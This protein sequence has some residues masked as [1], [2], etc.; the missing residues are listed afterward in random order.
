VHWKSATSA[1]LTVKVR[2]RVRLRKLA[3]GKFRAAVSAAQSFAGKRATFQRYSPTLRRWVALRRFTLRAAGA[4]TLPLNPT[5]LSRATFRS[6]VKRRLRV[7]VVLPKT[8]VG[9]CYVAGVGNV[10]RS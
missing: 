3:A 8:Q 10:I 2:P 9:A 6:K 1:P 5:T 4:T 7:R